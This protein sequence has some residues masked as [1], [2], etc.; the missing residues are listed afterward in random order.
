[1]KIVPCQ[2]KTKES[3][4]RRNKVKVKVEPAEEISETDKDTNHKDQEAA[5]KTKILGQITNSCDPECESTCNTSAT[6]THKQ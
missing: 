3:E 6:T 1:M 4:A 5:G 2:K